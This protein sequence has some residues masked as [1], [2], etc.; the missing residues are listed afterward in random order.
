MKQIIRVL[1]KIFIIKWISLFFIKLN[2]IYSRIWSHFK[3][4]ALVPNSGDSV[5]HYSVEI[6][7]GENISIGD[8]VAIGPNSCLGAK[9]K[10]IIGNN[11]RLS[12]GVMVETA[13]LDLTLE[14][15]YEHYSKP[16][17]IE[18]GVWVAANALIL[19]GVT[20]HK[21]ALIGAGAVITKDVPANAIIVGARNRNLREK[22][23]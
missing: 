13:A 9:S 17:V 6:K 18:D 21:N 11:V 4:K 14:P 23:V 12:R 7:F 20:I 3:F 2:W 8:G 22:Q 19:A 10:I 1:S 5:C 15:P 16:I